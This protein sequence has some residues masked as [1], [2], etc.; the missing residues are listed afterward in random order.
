MNWW[1]KLLA[2]FQSKSRTYGVICPDGQDRLKADWDTK[3][4]AAGDADYMSGRR[5]GCSSWVGAKGLK[6]CPG[7]RHYVQENHASQ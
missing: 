1:Q 4:I 7:G 5:L 6:D 2:L 3:Y